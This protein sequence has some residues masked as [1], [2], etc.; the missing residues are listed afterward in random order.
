MFRGTCWYM[1]CIR[2]HVDLLVRRGKR[3]RARAPRRF[4][5]SRR[6][7]L[8]AVCCH[9]FGTACS[10]RNMA[11]L[12]RV[13]ICSPSDSMR[14]NSS[15]S[16][17]SLPSTNRRAS[18]ISLQLNLCSALSTFSITFMRISSAHCACSTPFCPPSFA[19][20]QTWPYFLCPSFL[21]T[22]EFA[23]DVKMAITPT[24]KVPRN[25]TWYETRS[26]YIS[27]QCMQFMWSHS[28][29]LCLLVDSRRRHLD[30][31][32]IGKQA[33]RKVEQ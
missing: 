12:R 32:A 15:A 28:C 21:P 27:V 26:S 7:R 24:Y 22:T 10:A 33:V 30:V 25:R 5:A 2:S 31:V 20:S 17:A 1:T 19:G 3:Q 6:T 11:L 14:H 4:C 8:R 18:P 9:R 23:S 29:S 13:A 16:F